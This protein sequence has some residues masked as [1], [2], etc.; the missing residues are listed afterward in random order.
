MDNRVGH[1]AS[2]LSVV[3]AAGR[4]EQ[5]P[6]ATNADERGDGSAT[7]AVAP[8]GTAGSSRAGKRKLTTESFTRR[9]RVVTA[10]QFCRL[11][12]TKCDAVRPTCGYCLY[13]HAK[14]VY[15][16]PDADDPP[17]P[18]DMSKYVVE[19][20]EQILRGLGEV[21]QMLSQPQT[22]L[23]GSASGLQFQPQGSGGPVSSPS[24]QQ[25]GSS[26]A[27]SAYS[28]HVTSE[29]GLPTAP[30]SFR[31]P[32]PNS[33]STY[34][35]LRCEAILRW[36]IFK[37]LVNEG[38]ADI[39]SFLFEVGGGRDDRRPLPPSHLRVQTAIPPASQPPPLA[40]T[41]IDENA[42]VPLCRKFLTHVYPRNPILDKDTLILYA[43][44]AAANG[45]QWTA[46]SCLVLLACALA[47]FTTPWEP[48]TDDPTRTEPNVSINREDRLAASAYYLA[49]KKR[50]GVLGSSLIDI[51]CL[52]FAS[53]YEKYALRP[54]DAWFYIQTACTKLEALLLCHDRGRDNANNHH[55]SR[56][57]MAAAG[58]S[59]NSPAQLLEQRVFWTC[60]KAESELIPELGF[61]PS[62]LTEV[63]Y[64]DLFPT[65]PT[66]LESSTPEATFN[67]VSPE[68][69]SA[70]VC[71]DE[72]RSWLFYL[73]EIALRRTIDDTQWLFY[74][75]GEDYWINNVDLLTR[76]YLEAEK[77][78]TL[79]YSHLPAS[80][81][82]ER[83]KQPDNEFVF[84]L[85]H[86]F[87]HWR[88]S[89]LR[90]LLYIFLHYPGRQLPREVTECGN[91]A[92]RVA[93]E[94]IMLS[95]QNH[96]HGGIWFVTRRTFACDLL[97][98]AFVVKHGE[99]EA[100]PAWHSLIGLALQTLERWAPEA[101]DVAL[102]HDVLSRVYAA[103]YR[104]Q[105]SCHNAAD[106]APG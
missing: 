59:I 61:R 38:D 60:V 20:S 98:L 3:N 42:F 47:S 58:E 52:F 25:M 54:L 10:C 8:T 71:V 91:E 104:Q 12:K 49:G 41:G 29:G 74:H 99:S 70:T 72:N 63:G 50:L 37:G 57:G 43:K 28:P 62:G 15:D 44:D 75:R 30:A 32:Q 18:E 80:I 9:K 48:P 105:S 40:S 73:A 81:R 2:L 26:P 36:P 102:M 22:G 27:Y 92:M 19:L 51:Q 13:H 64:P 106:P 31:Q 1:L 68:P 39:R 76:Q 4:T 86:R 67:G 16:D 34:A 79:W 14:C 66:H 24:A 7:V 103:V 82:F 90:P 89:T 100:T 94:L 96:R 46:P 87:L 88:E 85:H 6:I 56:I 21:K 53:I 45:L 55:H 33:R 78:I 35:A 84:H 69:D 101:A 77:Q 83:L 95:A 23:R 93:T 5:S 97:V 17:P 65:P 11:R